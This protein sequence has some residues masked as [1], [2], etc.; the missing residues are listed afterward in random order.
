M[1]GLSD[2]K[3]IRTGV[4]LEGLN[5]KILEYSL[6]FDFK[7]INNLAKYK[8]LVASLQLAKEIRVWALNIKSNSQ[9]VIA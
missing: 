6:K 7:A 4:I 9:L 5:N 3:G 2:N 8:S 1:D